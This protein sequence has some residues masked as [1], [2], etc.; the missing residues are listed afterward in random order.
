MLIEVVYFF[1]S[2]IVEVVDEIVV[3][4]FFSTF[5]EE[6]DITIIPIT[7]ITTKTQ[8]DII[9]SCFFDIFL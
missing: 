7:I 4:C 3:F 5:D 1:S 9:I 6:S 2:L 8:E